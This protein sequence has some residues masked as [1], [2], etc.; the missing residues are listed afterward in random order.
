MG[1]PAA[2]VIVLDQCSTAEAGKN[3][4]IRGKF[5]QCLANHLDITCRKYK[6]ISFTQG[7]S[8]KSSLLRS[9]RKS[10]MIFS[11]THK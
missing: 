11:K 5:S 9:Q 8:M 3:R 7:A 6:L 4:T 10:Q 1:A 2:L